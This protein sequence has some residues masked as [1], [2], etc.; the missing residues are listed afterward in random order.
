[1]IK[2]D[3]ENQTELQTFLEVISPIHK[4]EV[5]RY[6][7]AK[8]LQQNF[9]FKYCKDFNEALLGGFNLELS[10]PEEVVI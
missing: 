3:K 7:F 8:C 4:E 6:L 5:I 9:L 10:S 1:M 2:I